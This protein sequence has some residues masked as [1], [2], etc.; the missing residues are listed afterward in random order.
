MTD[1]SP[2]GIIL[3]DK[4][5]GY[6]SMGVCANVRGKLKAGGAPKRIKVGHGGTLDPL[7]SGLLVILVGRATRDCERVMADTKVYE[8]TIDLSCSSPTQDLE[9]PPEP[10]PVE[11]PPTREAVLAA[12]TTFVGNI[13][14]VPPDH[15]AINIGGTRAYALARAGK[16]FVIEPR[17]VRIDD[18]TLRRYVWPMI[19]LEITCGKGTYIRSLARDIGATLGTG[20]V[21]R[22]LRRTRTGDYHV[23][24]AIPLRSLPDPLNRER[25]E[26]VAITVLQEE[27]H[28]DRS[29]ERKNKLADDI[30]EKGSQDDE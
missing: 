17:T 25:F 9:T 27:T 7:A 23:T 1:P 12:L 19:D 4:P 13:A 3:I 28:P 10:V 20:G 18:I 6:T 14:Q 22:S 30:L 21:L 11:H 26:S 5:L 8:T 2:A 29:A 24:E 15:S 16:P